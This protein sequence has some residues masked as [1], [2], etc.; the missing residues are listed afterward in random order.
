MNTL[1]LSEAVGSIAIN[2]LLTGALMWL[3]FLAF[4]RRTPSK[5]RLLLVSYACIAAIL[6]LIPGPLNA[7]TA[8][9]QIALLLW[10]LIG[11]KYWKR[12]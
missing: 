10:L 9:Q 8:Y 1:D 3:V 12:A 7:Q 11:L 5:E 2:M 6:L 4:K